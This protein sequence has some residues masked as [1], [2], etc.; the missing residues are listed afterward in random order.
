MPK[1][2]D[3]T[4]SPTT[5]G[6]VLFVVFASAVSP[7]VGAIS[8]QAVGEP[9]T[10]L[11]ASDGRIGGDLSLVE[12]QFGAGTLHLTEIRIHL[13]DL[14]GEG[15]LV[16]QIGVPDLNDYVLTWERTIR[17]NGAPDR[18]IRYQPSVEFEEEEITQS[19]YKARITARIRSDR[20]TRVV[21]ERTV[22]IEV[23]DGT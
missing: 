22:T 5:A 10:P 21:A 1:D 19:A 20:G 12:S 11:Q 13:A 6:L 14:V 17:S 18:T 16:V 3:G 4:V 7:I 15:T 8:E 23:E 2:T 9:E